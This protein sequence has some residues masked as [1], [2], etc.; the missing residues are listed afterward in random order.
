MLRTSPCLQCCPIELS[1][2]MEYSVSAL[3]MSSMVATRYMWL[4][5]TGVMASMCEELNFKF[6]VICKIKLPHAWLMG[7][8]LTVLGAYSQVGG[9]DKELQYGVTE[10]YTKY[11][12]KT[13]EDIYPDWGG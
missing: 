9:R 12:G 13:Q 11:Y 6:Y 8:I 4:L 10:L 5:N 1:T 3:S 2:K 7:T